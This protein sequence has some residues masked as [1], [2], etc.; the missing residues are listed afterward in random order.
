MDKRPVVIGNWKMELS[1]KGA[2]EVFSAFVK[3]MDTKEFPVDIAVCPS[4]P[5]LPA[6]SELAKDTAITI[7]AQ[8]IHEEDKGAY[9][10]SVSVSQIRE[11]VSWCIVGHSEVRAREHDT[12]EQITQKTKLLLSHGITPVVCI[13]ETQEQRE[14]EQTMQVLF[15]QIDSLLENL[16]RV[17]LMKTVIAYEPIWAIGSGELPEPNSVYEVMLS[18][19]KRI[20]QKHDTELADRVRL[21]YGGSVNAGN[22]GQYVSEAG[23]DGVLV[24][25]ASVHPRDFFAIVS[26]VAQQYAQ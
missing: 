16:D 26:N 24:G 2:V 6:I 14:Q 10:G 15:G 4:Y 1:H 5:E 19:R 12:N 3:M 23:A 25:G 17:S 18:I 20:S 9:T 21:L 13:G 8:N 22:V 7:G 11:F